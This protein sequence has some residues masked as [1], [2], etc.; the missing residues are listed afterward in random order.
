MSNRDLVLINSTAF[1]LRDR[2]EQDF[3]S[4]LQDI[5]I[6]DVR[7]EPPRPLTWYPDNLAWQ[8]DA[9]RQ[10][11]RRSPVYKELH[12]FLVSETSL[13]NISRQESVSMIP[14]LLLDVQADHFV[15]DMCAAPGSKTTQLIEAMHQSIKAQGEL[16]RRF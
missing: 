3:F 12:E 11:F 6:D 1:E 8:V 2:L 14:P 13:G 7:V 15:L 10:T 5:Q 4:R 9:N 16:P